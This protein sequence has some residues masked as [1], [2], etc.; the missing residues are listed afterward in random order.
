SL[1]ELSSRLIDAQEQE[2]K[3]IA[4]ELHD[5]LGQA[6]TAMSINL[7]AID[8]QLGVEL[9]PEIAERLA[10]TDSLITRTL[11]QMREMALDL[12][13]SMLDDL[14]LLPA[15]RW[16]VK[17]YENRTGILV[18]L[19][20]VG[21]ELRLPEHIETAMYRVVQEALTNV[22][23]HAR[24]NRV[25][26]RLQR[27]DSIFQAFIEDDGSGFDP[28]E[29]A[30]REAQGRGVG[31]VGIRERIAA[32]G[33]SLEIKSHPGKGTRLTIELPLP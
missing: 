22:A 18:D 29:V 9:D 17:R 14:G 7:S 30:D 4:Q 32:L 27:R 24:A 31:L 3:R 8:K 33:G 25:D 11:E 5:E 1:Q 28:A 26:I 16:Y 23:R 6:L 12:R 13:P 15:L 21:L 20:V 19:E 2:R 10:E